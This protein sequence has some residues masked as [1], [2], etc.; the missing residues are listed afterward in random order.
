M[1]TLPSRLA[2][3]GLMTVLTTGC[4][5][6][7]PSVPD[8]QEDGI[9]VESLL[10]TALLD[11]YRAESTYEAVLERFG[12]V[13]PFSNILSA[14]TRH[15]TAIIELFH[16]YDLP[17]PSNTFD[18]T[19]DAPA[20][21]QEACALGVGAEE[22]NV[23]MYDELLMSAS[24]HADIVAVFRRLRGASQDNHLPAFRRCAGE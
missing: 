16:A 4:A 22:A 9:S 7:T 13:R 5:V 18:G 8:R 10:T 19:V 17:V 12:D 24:G 11:E 6:Q 1:T 21:L 14:E 15:S 3:I 20:T 2:T 23:G